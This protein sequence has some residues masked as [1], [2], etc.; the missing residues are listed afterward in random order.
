MKV[1]F[2]QIILRLLCC[3]LVLFPHYAVAGVVNIPGFKGTVTPRSPAVAPAPNTTTLTIPGFYH[4]STVLTVPANEVPVPDMVRG[5]TGLDPTKGNQGIVTTGN[6]D[7]SQVTVYQISPYALINWLTFNIGSNSSVYFNQQGHANWAALNRIWDL[8]PSQI[9]GSLKADGKIFLI[10]QNGILFAPGSR[11]DVNT[12]VASALNI[13]NTD[14]LNNTLK[15]YL[16][17]GDGT[18]VD[19]ASYTGISYTPN[20]IVSNQG[21]INPDAVDGMGTTFLI[22]PRVENYGAINA[23]LG[24]IGLIAGTNVLLMPPDQTDTGSAYYVTVN[25]DFINAPMSADPDFGRAVNNGNLYADGGTAGM[26]GNNVDHWGVIRSVTAYQNN[27]GQV[28]LRAANKITTGADSSIDLHVDASIDPK[29]GRIR[30]VDDTF[31]I[32]PI[33]DIKG[34][35][36]YNPSSHGRNEGTVN[37][38]DLEGSILAPTGNITVAAARRVYLGPASSIDVSGVNVSNL[39]LPLIAS[40]Q[41]NSVELRDDYAQKDGVLQGTKITTSATSGSTI[42]DL[43]QAYLTQERTA[44][45]RS[46]GGAMTKQADGSYK[47]Q[48]GIVNI[49]ASNADGDIIVKQGAVVNISG[50][51]V[52]YA[53][54]AM[55]S[56]KLLSGTKIYDISNAP[57]NLHYDKV[58]GSFEKTYDRFGMR[59]TYTGLYYRGASPITSYVKGYTQGGDA[60]TLTLSAPTI[61]LDGDIYAGVTRGTYQDNRTDASA[62]ADALALSIARGLEIPRAGKLTVN[63]SSISVKADPGQQAGSINSGNVDSYPQQ[64][65]TTVLSAKILNTAGLGALDLNANGAFETKADVGLILQPGGEFSAQAARID[66]EGSIKVSNGSISMIINGSPAPGDTAPQR[67]VLGSKSSLDVSGERIDNTLSTDNNAYLNLGL[68]NGGKIEI[69]DKTDNGDGVFMASGSVVDASGGYRIDQKGKVTGGSAG[70][71]GIQGVNIMLEGAL[72][73]YAL[74]D[75][76]GKLA[77]GAI[78]LTAGNI[79]NGIF[80][81]PSAS[82]PSTYTWSNFDPS[83]TPISSDMKG[84][85]YLA[86]DRFDDTGFT[87]ITLNSMNNVTITANTVISPSLVR[88]SSPVPGQ[89][90]PVSPVQAQ[91][92]IS[93]PVSG[94]LVRLKP[95]YAYMAG[96]SSFSASAGQDFDGADPTLYSNNLRVHNN[97][98]ATVAIAPGAAIRTTPSTQSK[99]AIYAPGNLDM[100]GKLDSPGGQILLS[101][102]YGDVSVEAGAK[103]SAAGTNLPDPGSTPK[104][105]DVNRQPISAGSVALSANIGT[106]NLNAGSSIDISGS[107]EV[108]NR[109]QTADGNIVTYS[110]AGDP[111]SLSLSYGA[112]LNWNGDVKVNKADANNKGG[113]LA[114]IRTDSNNGLQ[115]SFADIKKYQGLGFDDLTLKS[116]NSLLFSDSMNASFGRK[117]TLDAPVI[118]G[119][120]Q[121]GQNVS[122]NAPWIVLTNSSAYQP[123][124]LTGPVSSGGNLTLGGKLGGQQLS[125]WIDVIGSTQLTGFK[126]VTLD[127]ARDIRL[128][129]ALYSNSIDNKLSNGK[130]AVSGNLVLD[131]DRVYPGNYYSFDKN[132]NAVIYPD[133]YSDF[134]VYAPGTVTI[135]NSHAS[136]DGPIYSAGG[137]LTVVGLGGIDV[138]KGGTLAAPLGTITLSAPG[139]QIYLAA[140]SKLTAAANVDQVNYGG[141]DPNNIWV[142]EVKT[143]PTDLVFNSSYFTSSSLPQKSV[144]LNANTTVA[145]NGSV[146][147]V[148]GSSGGSVFAYKFQP[149]IQGSIDPLTKPNRYVAI[150]SDY[151]A[152][153][154]QTVNLQGAGLSGTYTLLDLKYPQN[155]RY[156]FMP[157]AYIIE[158]QSGSVLPGTGSMSKDGYPLAIGYTGVADTSI[159]GTRPQIY[160]VRTAAQVLATEGNYVKQSIVS[161][162]GG[163]LSIS[164]NTIVLNGSFNGA[165]MTGYHGGKISLGGQNIFVQSSSTSLLPANFQFGDALDANLQG[166]LYMSGDTVKGF[167]EVDLGDTAGTSA[168]N[169]VTVEAGAQLNAD[170]ISLGASGSGANSTIT[171]ANGVQLN[172]LTGAGQIN[173]TTPGK[174]YIDSDAVMHA[175]NLIS[176][177]V[178]D[179][180]GIRGSGNLQANALML[181]SNAMFFGSGA[182]GPNDVG[183]YLTAGRLS[184]FTGFND[185]T[186]AS[187]SDIEFRDNFTLS[188]PHSLTLDAARIIDTNTNGSTVGLNAS[189]VNLNNSGATPGTTA[190]VNRGTLTATAADQINIGGGDVLLG[191][192]KTVNLNSANDLTLKGK[193]SLNTGNADLNISAARVVTA[194]DSSSS[195]KYIA[196]NFIINA[197]SGAIAMTGSAAKAATTPVAGGLLEIDART[198][199]LSAVV[200]SDGG[201][202]KLIASGPGQ[203]DGVIL[204]SG[205]QVLAQGTADAPGGKVLVQ[206]S[207]GSIVMETATGAL[208][209][210]SIDVSAGSQGDAGL[211]SLQ[212]PAG[213]VTLG[214]IILGAAKG[215]GK[216]GSFVLDT[217]SIGDITALNDK[218]TTKTDSLGN[219]ISGGFTESLDLRARTG[220]IDIAS[221]QTVQARQV[222]LTADD[223]SIGNGQINVSGNIIGTEGGSVGLYAMNDLNIQSGGAVKASSSIAGSPGGNVALS[224]EKGWVNVNTGGKVDVSGGVN[225]T[226]GTI[227]LRAQRNNNDV[228]INLAPGSLTG[229]AAVYAEAFKRYDYNSLSLATS[230]YAAT[231]LS[232]AAAYYAANTA[233]AKVQAGAAPGTTS[234]LLPGIEVVNTGGDITVDTQMDLSSK[235]ADANPGTLT[236]RAAGNLNITQNLTD[237][238]TTNLIQADPSAY[239]F[240]ARKS[241]GF[242]LVAGADRNSADYLAVIKGKTDSAGNPALRIADGTVVYTESAPINFSS[243]GNTVIGAGAASQYMINNTMTYNLASYTGAIHGNV[244]QDLILNG[245]V[246]Q[247]AIGNIGIEVGRDLQLNTDTN[248]YLGAVRTTGRLSSILVFGSDPLDPVAAAGATSQLPLHTDLPTFFWRYIDGGDIALDV[249]RSVGKLSSGQ[250]HTAMGSATSPQWDYF[251]PM[252]EVMPG[253]IMAR[254]S[255]YG[256]FSADYS[257]QYSPSPGTRGL[258]TMGGGNLSI[259]TGGDFLAQAGT[260]GNGDLTINSGGDIRGRF[261]NHGPTDT[262]AAPGLT[263]IH[264]LGNF[265]AVA[266]PSDDERVQV[267][268][269]NSKTAIS[270]LGD[271]QIGAIVNPDLASGAIDTYR[272]KFVKCSYTPD[273]SISLKT[274][275]DVT[276]AGIA[277]F[278]HDKNKAADASGFALMNEL[279][280]PA[281]VSIDAGGNINLLNNFTLTSSPKGNLRLS[282]GGDI[283]GSYNNVSPV[284][285]MSDIATD[286]WYGLSYLDISETQHHDQ[287]IANRVSTDDTSGVI[288]VNSHGYYKPADAGKQATAKPLHTG[289]PDAI[290]IQAG[291]DI[292]DM[293]F[294]LPKQ[295]KVTAGRDI[296]DIVYEG[297]NIDPADVSMIKAKG[298][299]SMKYVKNTGT[300]TTSDTILEAVHNGLI[301]GGPG[302]FMI[303]AGG[304]IDLGSLQDGIQAIGNGNNPLLGPGASS[305]IVL[306]GYQFDTK[307][308]DIAGF[309]NAIRS[310]GDEYAAKMAAGQL[311]DAA[312]LLQTTRQDT[313]DPLLGAPTGVGDINM[314]STQI[315]TSN[316]KADIYVISNGT[317]N[318][319]QTALPI[320]GTAAKKTGI[321]TG[322]GGGINIFAKKDVNV[323][324]SRVMTFFSRQDMIDNGITDDDIKSGKASIGDITIWSDQGNINAGRGSRTAVNASAPKR[325]LINGTY[326]TVF[327]PPSVGS[328]LRAATYGNNAPVP[329]NIHLFAPSGVIDAGEAGIAGGQVT[330]AA[331]KVTNA[332]NISFSSGSLGV[333]QQ[334]AGAA[335]IGSLSGSGSAAQNSQLT[336]GVSGLDTTR[337]QAAQIVEDIIAKWLDVKVVDFVEDGNSGESN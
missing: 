282:A 87:R 80:V 324:E 194:A 225:G 305:L 139:Q 100:A 94:D 310:A 239:D 101:S 24:Q 224:S 108:E 302:A 53:G 44:L 294:F 105:Y 257:S 114:I 331:L 97:L 219:V 332:A 317:I 286:Y 319:G 34:L 314:T 184:K 125:Q 113:S 216:G 229:A 89:T 118:A 90:G 35:Y 61:V 260:F 251:S 169:S 146:I 217:N 26:Y 172:A 265:G 195:K 165:A 121:S 247:T 290:V 213:G 191:G 240:N 223:Q 102:G 7:S 124:D 202:I 150:R 227:Y 178:N 36:K 242:N 78:T 6:T 299:I 173:L 176:L 241:W 66:H 323:Q 303:E 83:T 255:Q 158:A 329:G 134:T 67:I 335:N 109:M 306:S 122:L 33:V 159:R 298:N 144:T 123:P 152:Q 73:G 253:Q 292:S 10:N 64:T 280:L 283:K 60:G 151:F 312:Q 190:T 192:F 291:R 281:S 43:T 116:W 267:E 232:E 203:N 250:W 58:L 162:D 206:S 59:E 179:V 171:I 9:F 131:A 88:L 119:S 163:N 196:P 75:L 39:P 228:N 107:Q 301:Q 148:S 62:G 236:L 207:N 16:E 180:D 322:G 205:S 47:T 81:A 185:I 91:G 50:G 293:I 189:I 63:A 56:T 129:E 226:G 198:I 48:S 212:A 133:I 161:G 271:M 259:T 210:S 128:S 208:P 304:S 51:S 31:D 197:G 155:A 92:P 326:V 4:G 277:P 74:A 273:T 110:A 245:G 166:K 276:M 269:F 49:T 249:G 307:A 309:F 170:V 308:A 199:D 258:A 160:S 231:W 18:T 2:F 193:G 246:I 142:T 20:A 270:A 52:N 120:G 54:G 318:L 19:T 200:R 95:S 72:R 222:K 57:L 40:L 201:T 38:I 296:T 111:G 327:T 70:S 37:L 127:A 154:G 188:A 140:G 287:W 181:K 272:S 295:A 321:T 23:P 284:M 98:T 147:D 68:L 187:R 252:R 130:L 45:E 11:V 136:V 256:L 215:S 182:K 82:I 153:P 248:N 177:D 32:Q 334:S 141:I 149:G 234:Y 117:L 13:R 330:L 214:G 137:N 41:L 14:F 12:L 126:N 235:G 313:I 1:G 238:P 71:V 204:H 106:L 274:G 336:S 174:L 167:R 30:T 266:Q 289:D 17:K 15:F 333:P 5:S 243:G 328:G 263:E 65:G 99:I 76:N 262:T 183:L 254:A 175:S 218:L 279:V 42:G 337:A 21:V 275:G 264:A 230:G 93:T 27:K 268:L 132:G 209:A 77:G 164:G 315:A 103:I 28:E 96:P 46:I 85:L 86:A 311:A 220:N 8:N 237:N 138:E 135:Q 22:G 29:T 320:A 25:D 84:K 157:G 145:M 221:G 211:V 244:G 168:T 104:G 55:N 115:V 186:F 3:A 297:Q 278:Y 79:D 300:T 69:K 288:Y 316:G 112:N 143:N 233:L 325:T 156:A 285:M 261:L